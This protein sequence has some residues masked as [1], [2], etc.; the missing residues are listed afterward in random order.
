MGNY[1]A[2]QHEIGRLRNQLRYEAARK[3]GLLTWNVILKAATLD[4]ESWEQMRRKLGPAELALLDRECP[5][6]TSAQKP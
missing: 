6:S 2:S 1:R 5:R 4:D 3:D